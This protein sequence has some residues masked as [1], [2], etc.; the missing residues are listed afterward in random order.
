M[1]LAGGRFKTKQNKKEVSFFN[2]LHYGNSLPQDVAVAKG[3]KSSK[4]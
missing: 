2:P 3:L 4:K 1:K